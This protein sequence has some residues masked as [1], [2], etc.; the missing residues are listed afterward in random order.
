MLGCKPSLINIFKF[1]VF[2]SSRSDQTVPSK[3]VILRGRKTSL[4][5][6]ATRQIVGNHK[7]L[8]DKGG[9]WEL[10]QWSIVHR[11]RWGALVDLL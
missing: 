11:K 1:I 6:E 5:S 9:W 7:M 2:L 10:C 8:L 4:K 3:E